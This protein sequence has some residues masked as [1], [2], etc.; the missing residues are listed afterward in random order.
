MFNSSFISFLNNKKK[1]KKKKF[2]ENSTTS[3]EFGSS[4]EKV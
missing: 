1:I 4:M 2:I 3:L